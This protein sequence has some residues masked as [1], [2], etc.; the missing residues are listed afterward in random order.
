[1]IADFLRKSSWSA[2]LRRFLMFS[3]I[4]LSFP[5]F[6]RRFL[7]SRSSRSPCFLAQCL[8]RPFFCCF[9]S[10]PPGSLPPV[11]SHSRTGFT[12]ARHTAP[13]SLGVRRRLADSQSRLRLLLFVSC[14]FLSSDGRRSLLRPRSAPS[15]RPT[16][17][18]RAPGRDSLRAKEAPK[19]EPRSESP[20]ER[21]RGACM[22]RRRK[23]RVPLDRER[24][25]DIWTFLRENILF[26]W[27]IDYIHV[28]QAQFHKGTHLLLVSIQ[29]EQ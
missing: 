9:L 1:M 23:E 28:L 21:W 26:R 14:H 19:G 5:V 12:F 10:F 20:S 18:P 25:R 3:L 13:L 8:H 22:W 4:N 27:Q 15:V 2:F 11:P 16:D 29:G 17:R 7:V 6:S 24:R